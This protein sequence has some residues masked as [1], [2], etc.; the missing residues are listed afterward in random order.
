[1]KHFAKAFV[2]ASL[3]AVAACGGQGDDRA[4]DNVEDAAENRADMLEEQADNT[5]NEILEQNLEAQ[6]DAVREN[7]EQAA[8]A[9]DDADPVLNR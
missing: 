3:L 1:M 4:A 5:N 8:D 9:I 7:G 6:A 2:G